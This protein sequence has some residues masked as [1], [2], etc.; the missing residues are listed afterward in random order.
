VD[1]CRVE[2]Q[3]PLCG[4]DKS[5]FNDEGVHKRGNV[6]AR[7]PR[8]VQRKTGSHAFCQHTA[9]TESPA[10]IKS[11]PEQFTI[12]TGET[13]HDF[14]AIG[15]IHRFHEFG[16]LAA[17][18][19]GS[20]RELEDRSFPRDPKQACFFCIGQARFDDLVGQHQPNGKLALKGLGGMAKAADL[21]IDPLKE[22]MLSRAQ[23]L[24]AKQVKIAVSKLG[25]FANLLG[26]AS[27]A[28]KAAGEGRDENSS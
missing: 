2:T 21:Y 13:V 3:R 11:R 28:W 8:A 26:C 7:Y 23:P 4:K 19:E 25:E 5:E 6:W 17:L 18:H 1:Q 14:V 15:A 10:R 16:W 24:A 22:A 9:I 27:L 12:E 20:S